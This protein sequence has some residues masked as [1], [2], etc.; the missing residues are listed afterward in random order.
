MNKNRFRRVFSKRLGML[1]AVAENVASQGKQAGESAGVGPSGRELGVVSTM[2]AMA[3]AL[4]AFQPLVSRAQSLP[5]N[6]QVM[7]GQA[8]ISQNTNTMTVN[9]GTQRAVIDWNSFNVGT[10]NTV[11]FNQPNAQAQALNRVTGG[12]ASNIQGSLLANGQV[13]IQNANGVLFSKGSVVNVGSLLATTKS[14]DSNAFMAGGPLS[15]K[16]TGT[17]GSVVNDGAINAQGY[18]VLMGDQ[19]RNS[20][21]ISTAQGG[22]VALAAGDSAMVALPNGQGIQLTLTNASA[23]ALVENSGNI[24]ADN[25]TVLLTARGSNTLLN[26]VVNLS[27]VVRAGTVVADAGNTGDVAVTGKIDASNAVGQ[28][29]TVVLSGDRVGVFGNASID[30]SGATE[31]GKVIIGGD[32][33]HKLD[34]TQAQ[35]ML[36]DGV[37]FANF[38]QVD[39]GAKIDAGSAH[40]N[41]GFVETSGHSLNV[42]G[43]VSAAAPEGK[44]GEWLIDPTDVTISTG[45]DSN[46]SGSVTSG[47][48]GGSNSTATVKNTTISNALNAGTDVTI[49]T[50]SAGT[51]T[52]NIVQ[53]SGADITKTAGKAANLT[54]AANGNITLNGNITSTFDKLNLNLTADVGGNHTGT[55]WQQSGT[56]DLNGGTLTAHGDVSG[57]TSGN[58][59]AFSGTVMNVGGGSITGA[60][61]T[62]AGVIFGGN[63]TEVGNST[64]TVTGT[65]NTGDGVI[66]AGGG[67]LNV[68]QQ[69]NLIVNGASTGGH[70]VYF[71]AG[72]NNS[73]IVRDS[74]KAE[75][76]GTSVSGP[77]LDVGDIGHSN[78]TNFTVSENASLDLTGSSTGG[79]GV[80][81]GAANE[82]V[83]DSAHFNVLGTS[84]NH[85]GIGIGSDSVS[86][87]PDL[88]VWLGQVGWNHLFVSG[89]A[90]ANLTG[91]STT[92]SGIVDTGV[93]TI[94]DNGKVNIDGSGTVGYAGYSP[95]TVSGNGSLNI[96]GSGTT[97]SGVY[98]PTINATG[99]ATVNVSGTSDLAAGVSA[100]GR[101]PNVSDNASVVLDGVSNA[102]AGVKLWGGPGNVSGDGMLVVNGTSTTGS[103]VEQGGVINVSG[104]GAVIV[105]GLSDDGAG[106][107]QNGTIN[108]SGNGAT[109]IS[110]DSTNGTGVIEGANG[111]I[112]ISGNGAADIS[113]KSTNGNGA[114]IDGSVNVTD[115]G[116]LNVSGGS[117]NGTGVIV[118]P[119]GSI[120]ISG[121]GAADI[122]G[123]ST[124]G[125]GAVID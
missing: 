106:V 41:G 101:M 22:Q 125:N 24:K 68:S 91:T 100:H 32:S 116:T 17:N 110:G 71:A 114:V 38:T 88:P 35:S 19:V 30:A 43:Q 16:S 18:V 124:N 59:L 55:L 123:N 104:N 12:G 6:G 8:S 31:G 109:S 80:F 70:G 45:A 54:L 56:I 61:N 81:I 93:A 9:Q 75:F 94:T 108:I 57:E 15:L 27:G 23:N 73:V 79:M 62:G 36:Q 5:T 107:A 33:L 102:G 84:G 122:S 13:L 3:V 74:A 98:L 97:Q 63:F 92:G 53:Q 120:N 85:A 78:P 20:G 112:N 14:V 60:A 49:T 42:D 39:S 7:A 4:V 118:D 72:G 40:G 46:Y 119:N 83:M 69:S 64:L 50:A 25:G 96:A 48:S 105:S 52:G 115:N 76:S 67:N 111:S 26:T 113:G 11:Q 121:N 51:A 44:A 65:S 58:G 66:I 99:N 34:G 90:T 95:A 21:A 47:F 29:G 87:D 1:V 77:G 103:G 37:Q 82:Y 117:S 28:G 89:N 2:T 10:G 86:S